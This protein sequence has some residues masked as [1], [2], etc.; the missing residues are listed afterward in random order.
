MN[1]CTSS[2]RLS[3]VIPFLDIWIHSNTNSYRPRC[4]PL[5]VTHRWFSPAEKH[6]ELPVAVRQSSGERQHHLMQRSPSPAVPSPAPLSE[7]SWV[8]VTDWS[9][10]VLRLLYYISSDCRHVCWDVAA[11]W[12]CKKKVR[13]DNSDFRADF[14]K[15]YQLVSRGT[16]VAR[17]GVVS[18]VIVFIIFVLLDL[19]I[20]SFHSFSLFC[21]NIHQQI[22]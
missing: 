14:L 1:I 12:S 17:W 8:C 21:T 22:S 16:R 10:S 9:L 5:I 18:V 11:K 15:S 3:P 20:T 2:P 7:S 4:F 19:L 6:P 13:Y